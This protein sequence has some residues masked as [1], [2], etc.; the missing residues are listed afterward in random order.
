M[1]FRGFTV[2]MTT[3]TMRTDLLYSFPFFFYILCIGTVATLGI[4]H[5]YVGKRQNPI[6]NYGN[7]VNFTL[8]KVE[9][10][11]ARE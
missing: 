4:T 3:F 6:Y 1:S 8:L 11:R 7:L 2:N 5:S 10:H 9:L